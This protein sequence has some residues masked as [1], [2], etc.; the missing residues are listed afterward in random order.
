MLSGRP[1]L[2]VVLYQ[3]EIPQNTGNIARTCAATHTPLHLVEP[4]GFR[5]T[6]RYLK[7]AGLDYWPYVNLR[8]HPDLETLR[9]ALF[10]NRWVYFS[11]HARRPYYEFQ[12][13]PGDCLVFGAEAKGLPCELLESDPDRV[14]KI[15]LD[16]TRVRSLNLATTV[17]VALFEALRQLAVHDG[18]PVSS[19]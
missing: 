16:R 10:P 3:P 13:L 7:R 9:E 6:D 4:L 15:P 2:Q 5:L 1:P 14:L 17:G 8:V 12:F 18:N 11:A 19:F